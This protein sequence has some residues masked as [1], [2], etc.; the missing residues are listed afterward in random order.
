L[1][2]LWERLLRA[3]VGISDNFFELGGDSL[4]GIQLLDQVLTDFG[5]RIPYKALLEDAANV[6]GMAARIETARARSPMHIAARDRVPRI[7][8]T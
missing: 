1:S 7:V 2:S 3:R 4:R 5:V 6:A 8:P